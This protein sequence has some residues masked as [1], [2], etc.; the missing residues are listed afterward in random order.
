MNGT[1]ELKK[2]MLSVF[3]FLIAVSI[4]AQGRKV[5]GTVKDADGSGLPGV[6]VVE[7]GTTNGVSTDLDGA[8]TLTLTGA[9]PVLV[10][11]SIGYV[12]IEKSVAPS[13]TNLQIKMSEDV[14]VLDDVVVVGYGT[15]KR[16]TLTNAVSSVNSDQF[17]QGAVT[18]PLQLLQ[19]KVAGLAINTTSGDPNDS[20]VQLML[21]GVSTL[22]GNQ[23]PLVV[24]DGVPGTLNNISVDDIETIDV[25]KDGSAATIYGTRGTNGVILITTKKG[26]TGKATLSYHGYLSLEQISNEIDVLSPDEFRRLPELTDGLVSVI[27]DGGQIPYGKIK[28]SAMPG[29]ILIISPCRVEMH[30]PIIMPV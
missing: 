16:S 2:I 22:T 18:S 19:G 1:L 23:Q 8:F 21:R 27:N 13:Q 11:S 4:S 14:T 6:T 24:I 3:L 25:L 30:K 15:V 12:T 7:K 9:H 29:V 20:G 10:F 26:S 17:V 28:C 5:S